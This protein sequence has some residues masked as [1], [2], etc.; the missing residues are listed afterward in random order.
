MSEHGDEPGE[1]SPFRL[2]ALLRAAP[3]SNLSKHAWTISQVPRSPIPVNDA[4]PSTKYNPNFLASSKQLR[5]RGGTIPPLPKGREHHQRRKDEIAQRR[6]D[7]LPVGVAALEK[8]YADLETPKTNTQQQTPKPADADATPTA[9]VRVKKRKTVEPWKRQ[10]VRDTSMVS[11]AGL[12]TP[13]PGYYK[14]TDVNLWTNA[15]GGRIDAKSR[16]FADPPLSAL[17]PGPGEYAPST[18]PAS[19]TKGTSFGRAGAP[20][21]QWGSLKDGL[22]PGPGAYERASYFSG[23]VQPISTAAAA[24]LAERIP[25]DFDAPTPALLADIK[26]VRATA[27]DIARMKLRP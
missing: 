10:P 26:F 20:R 4:P 22:F 19:S 2:S 3:R 5:C 12:A 1:V 16:R 27:E 24:V 8:V 25:I 11:A 7:T 6:V 21:C 18:A 17:T 23:R 9:S 13:P 14:G 15:R